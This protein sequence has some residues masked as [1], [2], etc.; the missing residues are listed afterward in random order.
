MFLLRQLFLV[1]IV[2]G[3]VWLARRV[4][5]SARPVGGATRPQRVPPAGE[6]EMVRD[7]VCNT[8]L[9]RSRAVSA[10]ID[11]QRHFFCSERC[12]Q[13]FLTRPDAG[14]PASRAD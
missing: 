10:E 3:L 1:L 12:R 13:T 8:F 9:P 5:G 11:G 7:R 6:G 14:K 4:F 2:F